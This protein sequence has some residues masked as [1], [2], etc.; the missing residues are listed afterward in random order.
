[1]STI[2]KNY[3]RLTKPGIIYGNL[4]TAAAGFFVAGRGP[5]DWA[6]L[7]WMLLGLSLVIG[8]ACVFNNYFDR[9]ID[10]KMERTRGRAIAAGKVS[11]RAA[12]IFACALLPLGAGA[13]YFFTT[14][15]ALAAALAGF[16]VYVFL[17][18]PL[19]HRSSTAL[20]VG[21]VAGA[22]PVV[23][24][25]AA[26]ANAIDRAALALFILLFIWQLP[27]FIAIAFYRFNEYAAAGVPLAVRK[28]PAPAAKRLARSVFLASL[29]ILLIFCLGSALWRL[30]LS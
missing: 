28:E 14:P 21:A 23:A 22:M 29:V 27:H 4:L 7:L 13:L 3:Y 30:F 5:V 26:G 19:K 15:W 18:T 25:Y 17:Y 20:Y 2:I 8:S 24:G 6:L 1:M 10:A 11:G 16:F 12:I 9:G